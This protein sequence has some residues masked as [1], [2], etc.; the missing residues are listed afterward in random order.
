MA[1]EALEVII[2]IPK[3]SRNKYEY[4]DKRGCFRLD[5]V[6]YS[7]V[8]YPTDYG[9]VPDTL[10]EDGDHLD[11]LVIVTEPTFTGCHIF[12]RIV[13]VLSMSDEMGV[14][15]KILAVPVRDPRFDEFQGLDGVPNH[16][17]LEIENF[18]ATY[19]VL[20][21]KSTAT[22]GWADAPR[23]LEVIGAARQRWQASNT[24]RA[25]KNN[26]TLNHAA[27]KGDHDRGT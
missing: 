18:F 1:E 13:G 5:R 14:D 15:S 20:E 24:C 7:S 2:E 12:V 4:D 23:A 19:K 27:R 26:A 22:L 10:A 8:H 21:G 6:L 16:L 9:F 3:G 11:V 17:L 25:P